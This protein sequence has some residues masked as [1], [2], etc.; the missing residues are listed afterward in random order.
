MSYCG[1]FP[2]DAEPSDPHIL[3]DRCL[4]R[5]RKD[6]RLDEEPVLPPLDV[7]L[8]K[9]PKRIVFS[10][11][12]KASPSASEIVRDAG[13]PAFLPNLPDR[14]TAALP[15]TLSSRPVKTFA[16]RMRWPVLL[17]GFVAGVFGGAA[18][19]KSPIGRK[20][21]VQHVLQKVRGHSGATAAK[22]HLSR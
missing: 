11:W 22:S 16:Q 10:P 17:C 21:A 5:V 8:G 19:M 9:E 12:I 20:P 15:A 1:T 14:P 3:V 13:A 7:I 6:A 18:V 4:A 2:I